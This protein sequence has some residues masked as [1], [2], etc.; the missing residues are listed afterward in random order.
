MPTITQYTENTG[1][2]FDD[3]DFRP[4]VVTFPVAEGTPV[5]GAVLINAGGAFQFRSDDM[6]GT[7]GR[8]RVKS[9]GI[10]ELCR[11]LSPASLY[12]GR[13]HPGFGT[14]GTFCTQKC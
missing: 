3:P 8:S 1:N 4:Y 2:Y 10:S 14:R 5:K 11:Q 13:R 7:P 12:T 9:F 6:E